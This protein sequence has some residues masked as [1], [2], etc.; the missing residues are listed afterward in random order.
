MRLKRRVRKCSQTIRKRKLNQPHVMIFNTLLYP[1][2]S[3]ELA[4]SSHDTLRA[5]HVASVIELACDFP[6]YL[7][8]P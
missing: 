6:E 4:I 1:T 3:V 7:V 2:P 8:G 5:C